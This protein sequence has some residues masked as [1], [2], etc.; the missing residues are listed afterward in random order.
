MKSI[1]LALV[2]QKDM[3]QE[4][5]PDQTQPGTNSKATQ[6]VLMPTALLLFQNTDHLASIVP[7]FVGISLTYS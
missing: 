4:T 2:L 5:R 3:F 1:I 6:E 7:N